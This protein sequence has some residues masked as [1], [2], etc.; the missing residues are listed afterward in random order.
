MTS[1]LAHTSAR[2]C[3]FH[4]E[5]PGLPTSKF[6]PFWLHALDERIACRLAYAAAAELAGADQNAV[7]HQFGNNHAARGPQYPIYAEIRR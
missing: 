7:A 1:P 5:R 4:I 6:Q 3:R 2:C